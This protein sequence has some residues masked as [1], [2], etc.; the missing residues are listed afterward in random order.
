MSQESAAILAAVV[1]LA[2]WHVG[3]IRWAW[4]RF[5][6]RPVTSIWKRKPSSPERPDVPDG[7]RFKVLKRD[8]FRCVYCGFGVKDG[9]VLDVRYRKAHLD[10]YVPWRITKKHPGPEGFVTACDRCN[11]GKGGTVMDQPI[12]DFVR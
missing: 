3:A 7:T 2:L 4:R 12:T 5:V 1:I 8:A 10:H 6:V 11:L 9:R